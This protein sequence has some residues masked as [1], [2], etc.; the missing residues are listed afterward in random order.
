M[1]TQVETRFSYRDQ[2]CNYVQVSYHLWQ[3][4]T[5]LVNNDPEAPDTWDNRP[6][7]LVHRHSEE[8][9]A[10]TVSVY[11]LIE[12]CFKN[13]LDRVKEFNSLVTEVALRAKC[14]TQFALGLR[15]QTGFGLRELFLIYRAICI[16]HD[17]KVSDTF[18]KA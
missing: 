10:F 1:V 12:K 11:M 17:I 5:S 16:S 18:F 15:D 7:T 4:L 2:S 6:S 8:V 9:R 14:G 13:D 3:Y